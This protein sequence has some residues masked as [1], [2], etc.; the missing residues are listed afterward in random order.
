[1]DGKLQ[2]RDVKLT[3]R[4][5]SSKAV[6]DAF[7]T[8]ASRASAPS[9]VTELYASY[10]SERTKTQIKNHLWRCD[11]T[12]L[13]SPAP[14]W[15]IWS[16]SLCSRPLQSIPKPSLVRRLLFRLR[17]TNVLLNFR[18]SPKARAPSFPKPFHDKSRCFKPMFTWDGNGCCLIEWAIKYI[19]SLQTHPESSTKRHRPFHSNVVPA[20]IQQ[21]QSLIVCCMN[22]QSRH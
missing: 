10:R 19:S 11:V 14:T 22:E 13:T 6:W 16:V 7:L 2:Q 3:H 15:R 9:T 18:A 4:L 12:T 17:C 1:M 20:Q 5:I 21:F 8:T